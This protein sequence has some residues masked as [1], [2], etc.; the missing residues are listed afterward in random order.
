MGQVVPLVCTAY[1]FLPNEHSKESPLL[2]MFSRDPIVL[3]DS[4]LV[5]TVSY[6]G[7]DESILSLEALKICT[8]SLKVI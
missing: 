4:L 5:P 3:L 2:L 7:T 6:L 1:N 8:N